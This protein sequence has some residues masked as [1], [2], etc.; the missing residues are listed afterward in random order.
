MRLSCDTLTLSA[1]PKACNSCNLFLRRCSTAIVKYLT[2]GI[3]HSLNLFGFPS[4]TCFSIQRQ[5]WELAASSAD[6]VHHCRPPTGDA[7]RQGELSRRFSFALTVDSSRCHVPENPDLLPGADAKTMASFA[8][9]YICFNY[10]RGRR[11]VKI[12]P[13]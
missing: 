12:L 10:F 11:N 8:A 13:V 7:G 3:T 5:Q 1:T 2:L 9:N 4:K 6:S